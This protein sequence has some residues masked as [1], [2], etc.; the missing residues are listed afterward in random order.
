MLISL[1]WRKQQYKFRKKNIFAFFKNGLKNAAL[2]DALNNANTAR[3]VRQFTGLQNPAVLIDIAKYFG[4]QQEYGFRRRRN[5]CNET[6]AAWLGCFGNNFNL[7]AKGYLYVDNAARG[8]SWRAK[9]AGDCV[10]K[11]SNDRR[12]ARPKQKIIQGKSKENKNAI[13]T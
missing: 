8:T 1:Q 13:Y 6:R 7:I 9:R 10:A 11:R 3:F 2:E 12:G 5:N 4:K